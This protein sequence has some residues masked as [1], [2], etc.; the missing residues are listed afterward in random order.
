MRSA[1]L[2]L[3]VG[4]VSWC[5]S[6]PHRVAGAKAKNVSTIEQSAGL[7]DRVGLI[8]LW[9]GLQPSSQAILGA[10]PYKWRPDG[11]PCRVNATWGGVGCR[12]NRVVSLELGGLGLQ[13]TLS[14]ALA[15]LEFLESLWLQNNEFSG[16][17]PGQWGRLTHLRVLDL[18]ANNLTG[19]IDSPPHLL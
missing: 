12:G 17:L 10:L 7:P 6:P 19:A 8:A 18:R 11:M 9:Q 5:C 1:S 4:L 16:S 14:P 13:G 15:S 3:I 2:L